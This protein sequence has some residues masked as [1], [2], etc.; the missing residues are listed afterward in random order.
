MITSAAAM[1][2]EAGWHRSIT[3]LLPTSEKCIRKVEVPGMLTKPQKGHLPGS[4]PRL[5]GRAVSEQGVCNETPSWRESH[6]AAAQTSVQKGSSEA[7]IKWFIW[8]MT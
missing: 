8:G 3:E 1:R 6:L 2:L 4:Q 5:L 7:W